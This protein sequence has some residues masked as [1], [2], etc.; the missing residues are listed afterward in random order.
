MILSFLLSF[1]IQVFHTLRSFYFKTISVSFICALFCHKEPC[2]A[3][4]WCF[5]FFVFFVLFFIM[6]LLFLFIIF[7][8]YDIWIIYFGLYFLLYLILV[9]K[10]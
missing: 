2:A 1:I 7:Y 8:W 10:F 9:A 3:L 6:F 5:C 4:F